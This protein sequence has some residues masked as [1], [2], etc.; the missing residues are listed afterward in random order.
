M[1]LVQ[2]GLITDKSK[3]LRIA[4]D[5]LIKKEQLSDLAVEIIKPDFSDDETI[6]K[7]IKIMV[8]TPKIGEKR[9]LI[10]LPYRQR[11][12]SRQ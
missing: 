4:I 8:K 6:S 3:D 1:F 2:S 5:E 12:N 7:I 10:L 11:I 9:Y